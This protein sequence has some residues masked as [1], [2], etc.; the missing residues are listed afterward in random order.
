[1]TIAFRLKLNILLATVLALIMIAALAAVLVMENHNRERTMF[2]DELM[3]GM[4]ELSLVTE[5]YIRHP[6]QRP[7]SQWKRKY[8]SLLKLLQ[9]KPPRPEQ[10][11]LLAQA[12]RSLTDIRALFDELTATYAVG[13]ADGSQAA[14]AALL[15][16]KRE[17]LADL[18]TVRTRAIAEI[19]ARLATESMADAAA[20]IR[21]V[22]V[23]FP[24]FSMLML[25]VAVWASATVRR[26][27]ADPIDKLRQG[28]A[29]IGSGDLDY[30]IGPIFNDELGQLAVEFDRMAERLKATT[31]SRGELLREVAE[32][33]RAE[34]A[35][36]RLNAELEQRVKE[37]TAQLEAANREL[38]TFTYSVSHDLK[39]PLRGIDGYS[40]L[41]LEDYAD[42]L[43]EEGKTFLD[44]VRQGVRQMNTLIDDLLAYS[45]MERRTLQTDAVDLPAFVQSLA[46]EFSDEMHARGVD[47]RLLLPPLTVRA[48]RD[49]LA[50][51]AR[52][53]LDN[54]LKF[55]RGATPPVIEIS[56]RKEDNKAIVWIRDNGIGFDMKFHDRIFEIFQRLHRSEDYPGSGVGLALVRRAMQRMGGRVW[57]QSSP[58]RGATFYLELPL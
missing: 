29:V 10:Q 41:L 13:D 34:E 54:A 48:D 17:L 50:M 4:F 16:Q 40:R 19:A 49:G 36:R 12:R 46:A 20:A 24:L 53:L 52:N 5:Y 37:R 57:A 6:E 18:M 23:A 22:G 25:A 51:V 45:R 2:T 47:F 38:K 14:A 32:R 15:N 21:R 30:R 1:M 31:A 28:V 26:R 43:D 7:Q 39:A 8:D 42:R 3:R 44:N 58:G 11:A 27:I 33:Q 9:E 56:G 55:T 35:I